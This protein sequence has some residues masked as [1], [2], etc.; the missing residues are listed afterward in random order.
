MTPL[1]EQHTC[2]VFAENWVPFVSG[3]D[4]SQRGNS[5][6]RRDTG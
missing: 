4:G 1:Q 6:S 2:F 3:L 5:Q